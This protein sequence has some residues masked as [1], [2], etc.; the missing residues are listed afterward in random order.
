MIDSLRKKSEELGLTDHVRFL[1]NVIHSQVKEFLQESDYFLHPSITTSDGE[2]EGLPNAIMEALAVGVPV[3]ATQ[4]SG[5]EE[6]MCPQ[7]ALFLVEEKNVL[8][9]SKVMIQLVLGE[10]QFDPEKSRKMIENKFST[11][12]H[13]TQLLEFYHEELSPI[14]IANSFG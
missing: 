9:Y 2:M 4:H 13:I 5:M 8:G 12:Q 11:Q 10:L 6:L 7:G 14:S 3:I 1:D